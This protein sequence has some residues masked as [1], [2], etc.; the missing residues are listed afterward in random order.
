MQELVDVYV[1]VYVYVHVHGMRWASKPSVPKSK[2]YYGMARGSTMEWGALRRC[3]NS[4][5][6]TL[7]RFAKGKETISGSLDLEEWPHIAVAART[8][9]RTSFH[10]FGEVQ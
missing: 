8:V 6:S 9:Q 10:Y 7:L 2:R 4:L 1:D 3:E 5:T